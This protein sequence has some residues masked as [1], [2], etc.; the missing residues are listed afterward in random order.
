[1]IGVF[2]SK[3]EDLERLGEMLDEG[4]IDREEYERLKRDLLEES[5]PKSPME[6]KSAGWYSDP[7]GKAS[8]QAYWNGEQWTG[9]TR[10]SPSESASSDSRS[11]LPRWVWVVGGIAILAIWIGSQLDSQ[12]DVEETFEEIAAALD[13]DDTPATSGG[14]DRVT[15]EGQGEGDTNTFSLSGGSYEIR[16]EVGNDCYYSF[17]LRDPSDG[18]RVDR[19]TTMSEPGSNTVSLHGISSGTYYVAVITGPAP[20]CPWSQRWTSS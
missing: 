11:G 3:V 15:L 2:V 1:M 20:A 9:A 5:E 18:S 14:N 8:H 16:T 4:K 13:N 7:A 19:I 17:T 6:E 12:S 10:P